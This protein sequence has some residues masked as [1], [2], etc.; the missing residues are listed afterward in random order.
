MGIFSS[1][2][3]G[4]GNKRDQ[5]PPGL[6]PSALGGLM[7]TIQGSM[8]TDILIMAIDKL[9]EDGGIA[10][11]TIQS[12]ANARFAGGG[13]YHLDPAL[14]KSFE[15]TIRRAPKTGEFDKELKDLDPEY[16][17]Y[18]CSEPE[19]EDGGHEDG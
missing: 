19:G 15:D 12:L 7:G 9:E 13:N 2:F 14:V 5:L 17:L 8:A 16:R 4:G 6:D 11:S 3:G 18:L 1:L 10:V